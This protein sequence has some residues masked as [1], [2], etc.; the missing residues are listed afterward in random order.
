MRIPK[1]N[2]VLSF[3]KGNV[4]LRR[5]IAMA[6]RIRQDG[7]LELFG[8][9]VVVDPTLELGYALA[10]RQQEFSTVLRN[11]VPLLISLAGLLGPDDTFLDIGA[12]V[13][14]YSSILSRMKNIFPCTAFH[15][16]EVNPQTAQRLR[17]SLA[18]REVKIHE[19]GLSDRNGEIIFT[20]AE[21]SGRFHATGA[22]NDAKGVPYPVRRLDDCGIE[23]NSLVMK[24]DVEG[25]E[26]EVLKGAEAI[27]AAKRVKAVYVD[28]YD[29]PRVVE[30][31]QARGFAFFDGLT[32]Q[33][34]MTADGTPWLLALSEAAFPGVRDEASLTNQ[35]AG[36]SPSNSLQNSR[37]SR[38]S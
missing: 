6:L 2:A 31:L 36:W 26:F 23:G 21:T 32:M 38:S 20:R 17:R 3:I 28:G 37:Q 7:R 11:D 30:F 9:P 25:H 12:N 27:F 4:R 13:G 29:D 22:A 33:R 18:S 5:L 15:A 34:S 14:F 16:F 8:S 10:W 1:N 24:I 35:A 19:Y